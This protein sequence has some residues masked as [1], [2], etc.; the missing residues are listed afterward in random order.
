MRGIE[1]PLPVS[2]FIT[3]LLV[4]K[5][6]SQTNKETNQKVFNPLIL[7]FSAQGAIQSSV[8]Y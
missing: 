7:Q 1:L 4:L 3:I 2:P 8:Y 6:L 5:L